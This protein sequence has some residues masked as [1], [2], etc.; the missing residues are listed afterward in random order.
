MRDF[1]WCLSLQVITAVSRVWRSRVT[2]SDLRSRF[3]VY[4]KHTNTWFENVV[5]FG[6]QANKQLGK[7]KTANKDS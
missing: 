5:T 3:P 6:V 7:N 4:Q 2:K 1:T